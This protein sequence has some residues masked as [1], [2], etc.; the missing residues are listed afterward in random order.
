MK[1]LKKWLLCF[2]MILPMTMIAAGCG[3][4]DGNRTADESGTQN[5]N[6]SNNTGNNLADDV[7]DGIEDGVNYVGEGVDDLTGDADNRSYDYGDYDDA[8][9]YLMNR[10]NADNSNRKYEVRKKERSTT[11][12]KDG[13]KG[14]HY[15]I[16]DMT[17]GGNGKKYGDFY[18]DQDTGKSYRKNANTN[19]IEEY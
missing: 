3:N 13:Q 11:E 1:K 6:S 18:V 14:Y 8:H 15:E 2:G 4:M 16:Y 7:E 5:T 12:Y 17:D 19:K 10:L 9:D